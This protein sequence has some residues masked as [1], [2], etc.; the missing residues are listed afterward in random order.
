W[1]EDWQGARDLLA[2]LRA[3]FAP[4]LALYERNDEVALRDRVAAHCKAAESVAQLPVDDRGEA[5]DE[6]PLWRDEA[7]ETAA[8]F[9]ASLLD[10]RLP[11]LDLPP[12]DYADLYRSLAA[13]ETVRPRGP[14]HPRLF[15]WGPFEAR[16][17][18]PD[19]VI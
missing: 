12:A 4:L 15:I 13:A 11:P 1:T 19:I 10:P 16:L 5:N 14:V 8:R 9:F 6:S 2:R 17:Q 3:A 7:G 18:Q